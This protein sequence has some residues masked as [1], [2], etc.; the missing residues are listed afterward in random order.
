MTDSN[1]IKGQRFSYH[2]LER[3]MNL[4][5]GPRL[6]KR[7]AVLFSQTGHYARR[8]WEFAGFIEGET[9]ESIPWLGSG[10][11][12]Q[13]FLT[14]CPLDTFLDCFTLV[15]RYWRGPDSATS[16]AWVK[17]CERILR[18]EQA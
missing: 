3:P 2:Y 1:R 14:S 17:G 6:R 8:N 10:P 9:G 13:K 18:E 15:A 12:W 16:A 5:D 4:N 7:V 11:D